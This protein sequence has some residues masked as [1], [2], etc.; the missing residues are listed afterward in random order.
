LIIVQVL[1]VWD[2]RRRLANVR[3]GFYCGAAAAT[4]KMEN[5][6]D[7]IAGAQGI[8]G[9]HSRLVLPCERFYHQ[10]F[11]MLNL[12]SVLSNKLIPWAD[13]AEERIIVARPR[14]RI[15]ALPDD[16]RLEKRE[17]SGTRVV[18]RNRRYYHNT[19]ALTASWPDCDLSEVQLL[20]MACILTGYVDYQLGKQAILC[21]PG[22]FILIPPGT[23]HPE[24]RQNIIDDTR[25]HHCEMMYFHLYPTALQ[26]W[27][28]GY[29]THKKRQ[30]LGNF[31][32]QHHYLIQLF[33]MMMDETISH[34][35]NLPDVG[36]ELLRAF[37]HLLRM[38]VRMG[39]FQEVN[40]GEINP[41]FL[42]RQDSDDFSA[43]LHQYI[44]T[45][46]Q[47][48]P[49][50]EEAA[51]YMCLSRTQFAHRVRVETGKTF[52]ELVNEHRIETAKNLLSNSDWTI[53]TISSF[54]GYRTPHYFQLLFSQR[55][56]ITPGQYRQ[57]VH[58]KKSTIL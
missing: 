26:C 12:D 11:P 21:G 35:E 14:M 13:T 47:E 37:F 16:V 30:P 17:L 46:L 44:Q 33:R 39:L 53:T 34:E 8:F 31:L 45:H 56:G 24:G 36:K 23:P 25:C 43:A 38:K 52:I 57:R 32:F 3:I 29:E 40:S 48:R 22:H 10:L 20:K 19:R 42:P 7:I 28:T 5:F 58:E 4:L 1:E 9:C 15:S 18:V 54:L 6:V 41:N 2:N 27:I 49:K 55:L 51:R 50:L